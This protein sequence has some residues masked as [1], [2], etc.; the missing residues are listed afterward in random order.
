MD[1]A[2]SS[3]PVDAVERMLEHAA[4]GRWDQ[5]PTVLAHDFEIVEPPSLPY[6]GSH[7]GVDGYVALMRRIG[8][9]FELAFEP[10]S[11][12]ALDDR[13]VVLRMH[14]S[15]RARGT[16]RAIRM[17]VVEILTLRANRIA[18]SEVFLQDTA[19][20]LATLD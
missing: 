18:R 2:I 20:L 14:V 5:L 9:L 8:E 13:T 4:H 15:F 17:P 7:H 10:D 1:S 3:A 16:G 6:G 11:V 12:R 19:G